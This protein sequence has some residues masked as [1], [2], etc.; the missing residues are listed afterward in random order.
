MAKDVLK[1][2]AN[3]FLLLVTSPYSSVM[4]ACKSSYTL[5][6]EFTL[7]TFLSVCC[8][9]I[10]DA[11]LAESVNVMYREVES[12]PRHIRCLQLATSSEHSTVTAIQMKLPSHYLSTVGLNL[13]AVTSQFLMG[14][15]LHVSHFCV[16]ACR[17]IRSGRYG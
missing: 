10:R 15:E 9:I 6:V 3:P 8:Y 11:G 14:H 7:Q 17:K 4:K 16:Y 5:L 13:R 2:R 12:G 1:A